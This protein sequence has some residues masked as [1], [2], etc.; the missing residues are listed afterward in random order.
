VILTGPLKLTSCECVPKRTDIHLQVSYD[1]VLLGSK[2]GSNLMAT[3]L[4]PTQIAV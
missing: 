1:V 3:A 4:G 2:T